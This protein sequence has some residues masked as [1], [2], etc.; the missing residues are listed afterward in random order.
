MILDHHGTSRQ[1]LAAL[2][3][4]AH[5]HTF[6]F[7]DM[8]STNQ[9]FVRICMEL[10]PKLRRIGRFHCL[11]Y[12]WNPCMRGFHNEIS[13]AQRVTELQLKELVLSGQLVIPEECSL[14]L[15]RVMHLTNVHGDL[16]RLT[17]LVSLTV[18]GLYEVEPS[19][20]SE[21][22]TLVGPRLSKLTLESTA[23]QDIFLP[24]TWCPNL[25]TF[26]LMDCEALQFPSRI[27]PLENLSKLCTLKIATA[28]GCKFPIGFLLQ[29]LSA[30]R[31]KTLTL[32]RLDA[33]LTELIQLCLMIK[34]K[35]ILQSLEQYFCQDEHVRQP[36][37]PENLIRIFNSHVIGYCPSIKIFRKMEYGKDNNDTLIDLVN[38]LVRVRDLAI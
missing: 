38:E 12:S 2:K 21:L 16:R 37:G 27:I 19:V 31:L 20:V 22:L 35:T 36:P 17:S 28:E 7:S 24:F 10:L 13:A 3:K 30:P 8:T 9:Q 29:V 14:P 6:I 26:E 33:Q 1:G 4:L 34:A 18:L 11:L 32:M 23:P 5:L 25:E 15:L